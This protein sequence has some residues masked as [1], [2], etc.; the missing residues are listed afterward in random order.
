MFRLSGRVCGAA[1]S[2]TAARAREVLGVGAASGEQEW[3]SAFRAKALRW[4]PDRTG[5]AAAGEHFLEARA[6]LEALLEGTSFSPSVGSG[7]GGA[8]SGQS[9][10]QPHW[11]YSAHSGFGR[12]TGPG[13]SGEQECLRREAARR[14]QEEARLE[15]AARAA[16]EAKRAAAAAA[17][18]QLRRGV[19]LAAGSERQ[20]HG[21]IALSLVLLLEVDGDWVKGVSINRV[22]GGVEARDEWV[23][24]HACS[25]L[26]ATPNDPV[27]DGGGL[28]V[29]ECLSRAE[30]RTLRERLE[31]LGEP[32]FAVQGHTWWPLER[33]VSGVERG[34]WSVLRWQGSEARWWLEMRP[35]L[36]TRAMWRRALSQLQPAGRTSSGAS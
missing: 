10:Q 26:A 7:F 17:E 8:A 30:A 28:Y 27:A 29:E 14:R 18:L 11:T 34:D 25:S 2:M 3:K 22:P 6:A 16:A 19:L 32:C 13:P 1:R 20:V 24:F 33:L 35:K 15:T 9:W 31:S 12:S 4:H 5:D 23:L 21:A 36:T